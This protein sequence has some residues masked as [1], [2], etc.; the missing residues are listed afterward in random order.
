MAAMTLG[1]VCRRAYEGSPQKY[2]HF[3]WA[4][5]SLWTNRRRIQVPVMAVVLV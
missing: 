5:S 4:P 3:C 2:P 1:G